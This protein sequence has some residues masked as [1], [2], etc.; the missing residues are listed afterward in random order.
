MFT[1]DLFQLPIRADLSDFMSDFWYVCLW[2]CRF[3]VLL[4]HLHHRLP[5]VGNLTFVNLL[6]LDSLT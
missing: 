3:A 5:S 4:V 2:I 1:T 6:R